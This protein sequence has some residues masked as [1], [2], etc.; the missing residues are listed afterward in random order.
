MNCLFHQAGYGMGLF[1][2]IIRT[3]F[4]LRSFRS[5]VSSI[6]RK[7]SDPPS[8]HSPDDG[9]APFRTATRALYGF[10]QLVDIDVLGIAPQVAM[11]MSAGWASGAVDSIDE[12]GPLHVSLGS[13]RQMRNSFSR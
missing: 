9:D 11:T 7:W 1:P 8:S 3:G 5:P 6:H 4:S 10:L 2:T 13:R 12:R